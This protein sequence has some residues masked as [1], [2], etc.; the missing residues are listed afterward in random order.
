MYITHLNSLYTENTTLIDYV[1][2]PQY[3]H[4]VSDGGMRVSLGVKILPSEFVEYML[5][6]TNGATSASQDSLSEIVACKGKTGLILSTGGSVWTGYGT[7]T[8][9]SDKYPKHRMLPLGMTQI[10]AGQLANKLGDIDY[11]STD[12][13]SCIS[14]HAALYEASNLI[15][16]GRLDR[17]IVVSSDNGASEEYMHF[18]G[19][20]HLCLLADEEGLKHK[21]RLGQGAN[22][23]VLESKAS[24]EMTGST[25]IAKLHN[26]NIVAENHSNP[27]GISCTG[28]GY[29]K[30]IVS[31]L[32]PENVSTI[33]YVKT[34]STYSK[35]N[36]IEETVLTEL[37]GNVKTVNY[38]SRIGHIMGPST[39]VEMHLSIKELGG[40]FISLGAGMGNVFSAAL[41]ETL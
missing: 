2:Y 25:P 21:F 14:A 27:L 32:T 6:G 4:Q 16:A 13:T 8:P 12:S 24:L 36:Q 28:E 23:T 1:S 19:E 15:K 11:V 5:N 37:L 17:V 9:L 34:H 30:A 40:T 31:M 38:K 33:D 41:V 7:T 39:A 29:K 3:V 35:D 20:N 26:I 18:F 22:I 10:Y